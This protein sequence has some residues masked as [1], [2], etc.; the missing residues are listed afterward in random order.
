MPAQYS[1]RRVQPQ[2]RF[3][4]RLAVFVAVVVLVA[5]T[6]LWLLRP[7]TSQVTADQ[8]IEVTMGGFTPANL[9]LAA[10]K[11]TTIRL[12]NPDSAYHMDGG[13]VHQFAVPALGLDIKVQPKSEQVF[14]IPA[15]KPGTY[16]FYCDV[17]CGGKENPSMQ[18]TIVVS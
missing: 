10:G 17:C 1:G 4:L 8:T 7:Q 11:P 13:G 3:G 12:V 9:A 18:G 2:P 5:G 16:A 14:T 15:A 6:A